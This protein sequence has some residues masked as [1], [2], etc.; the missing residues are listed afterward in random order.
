ML[1]APPLKMDQFEDWAED[2]FQESGTG[3]GVV[4]NPP[5]RDKRGWD[6]IVEWD[7]TPFIGIARDRQV[8]G[9][10]AR[11]QVKSCRQVKPNARVKLSN[12]LRFVEANEPCFIVLYHL[13]KRQNG[14][15]I[16]A[17]HFDHVLIEA[18]LKR[19]REA[20]RDGKAD[21]HKIIIPVTMQN[22]DVH[23]DDLIPW[24]QS[25]CAEKPAVYASN[26]SKI[27]DSVGGRGL[28]GTIKVPATEI[29]NFI[30]HAVGLRDFKSEWVEFRETRFGIPARTVEP[31]DDG[32]TYK[33]NVKPRASSMTFENEAGDS[34]TVKGETRGVNVT[35]YLNTD[36]AGS[37]I[38][39]YLTTRIFSSLRMD[40]HYHI[41]GQ[42]V[43]E[44]RSLHNIIKLFC[45]FGVGQMYV[46]YELEGRILDH[47]KLS[48]TPVIDKRE[49]FLWALDRLD[50]LLICTR[51]SEH[52]TLSLADLL[53]NADA[54]DG[55]RS[56]IAAEN[57]TLKIEP[58]M[59]DLVLPEPVQMAGY[60]YAEIAG[61]VYAAF[62]RQVVL[63]VNKE[64]ANKVIELRKP[65]IIERWAR[66][67]TQN[68]HMPRIK[69]KFRSIINKQPSGTIY[70]NEGD[71]MT[72]IKRT[73][74]VGTHV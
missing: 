7:E 72:A 18:T 20:E 17:R 13:D 68:I 59:Q 56:C 26:K 50:A 36:L 15:E 62:Y 4:V 9:R 65:D 22:S 1:I 73:S 38:S 16:Y 32:M 29:S 48:D 2:R 27:R 64:G 67:G 33:V 6:F 12:M 34:V 55:F 30:E 74:E 3:T 53:D 41:N 47:A 54:L 58:K 51:A 71:M 70:F 46:K 25:E 8:L 57:T 10:T 37:F 66:I 28:V 23:T 52:P 31:K 42:D 44:I 11:V 5:R 14:V 19:A 45:M 43:D 60:C 35:G 39:K 69:R 49:I 24:L 40:T 63:S 21:H 61:T